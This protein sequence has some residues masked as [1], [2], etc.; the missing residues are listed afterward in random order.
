M[1]TLQLQDAKAGFSG[2]VEE[3]LRG[4]EIL[5]TKHG[6]PAAVLVSATKWEHMSK[7]VPALVDV[8]M[9]FPG[10]PTDIAER[11]MAPLRDI[12]F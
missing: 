11:N 9:A 7:R 2:L 5:V 12:E 10:E 6:R 1:K 3:A 8:L 4:E